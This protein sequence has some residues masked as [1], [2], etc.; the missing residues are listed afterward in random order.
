VIV[1]V[2]LVRHADAGDRAGWVGD[3]MSRPL[4]PRGV[5]QAAGLVAAM[6]GE[7]V[8]RVLSSPYLRCMQ[9]VAP[10][11][12]ARGVAVD[13]NA[14]LAEGADPQEALGLIR[15]AVGPTVMC[16][17]GDVIGGLLSGLVRRGLIRADAA[18]AQKASTWILSVEDGEIASASYR[19]PP[20]R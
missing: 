16:S 6:D 18:R 10:L 14:G 4:S 2:F 5:D 3:D 8:A 15:Q 12:T 17:Q 9:T 11:A 7:Q 20:G 19:P 13:G 1:K